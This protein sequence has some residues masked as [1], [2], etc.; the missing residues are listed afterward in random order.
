[1]YPYIFCVDVQTSGGKLLQDSVAGAVK[2]SLVRVQWHFSFVTR[3]LTAHIKCFVCMLFHDAT[4]GQHRRRQSKARHV[5]QAVLASN[6]S[7]LRR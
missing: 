1:M 6:R 5:Q 4:D 2:A 7:R 3:Y